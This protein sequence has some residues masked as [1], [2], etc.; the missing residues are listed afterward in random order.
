[1]PGP[2]YT[3][4]PRPH[5]VARLAEAIGL[6]PTDPCLTSKL[7][8]RLGLD[9]SWVKRCRRLGL[10]TIGADLWATRAGLHPA[11]VWA[12]WAPCADDDDLDFDDHEAIAPHPSE[13]MPA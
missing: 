3:A 6:D 2:R 10:T 12:D 11:N 9:R 13:K 1:M 5:P 8:L 4:R 7:T